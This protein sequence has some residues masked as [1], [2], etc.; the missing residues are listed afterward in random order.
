MLPAG[1][2]RVT[3]KANAGQTAALA[4]ELATDTTVTHP[5]LRTSKCGDQGAAALGAALE[6]NSSLRVLRVGGQR[7]LLAKGRA[8]R[9]HPERLR[10]SRAPFAF[11]DSALQCKHMCEIR[12]FQIH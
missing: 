3:L 1:E 9:G 8:D 6:T 4:A 11:H 12:L 7:L 10:A 2:A 5:T